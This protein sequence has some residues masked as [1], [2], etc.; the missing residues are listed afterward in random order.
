V[1]VSVSQERERFFSLSGQ[2]SPGI[3]RERER[4]CVCERERE[5]VYECVARVRDFFFLG[6]LVCW[7]LIFGLGIRCMCVR[8]RARARARARL[9][10]FSSF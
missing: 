6:L 7:F 5:S 4:E 2:R 3:L 1:R 9:G 10:V 8:A